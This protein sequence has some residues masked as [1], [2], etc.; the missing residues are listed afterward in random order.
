MGYQEV[1]NFFLPS[2]DAGLCEASRRLV[3]V[4]VI[5]KLVAGVEGVDDPLTSE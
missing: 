5:G 2:A 4:G 3:L 1:L